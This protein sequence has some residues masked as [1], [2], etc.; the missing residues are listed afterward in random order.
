[1]PASFTH[2]AAKLLLRVS[3]ASNTPVASKT[4]AT[5]FLAATCADTASLTLQMLANQSQQQ[6]HNAAV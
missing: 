4:G 3:G 1:L 5:P 6:L 2:G